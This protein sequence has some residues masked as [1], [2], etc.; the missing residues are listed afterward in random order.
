MAASS[1]FTVLEEAFALLSAEPHRLTIDGRQL[2]PGLPT[3]QI[4][5]SELRSIVVDPA[6]ATDLQERIIQAV[7]DRLQQERDSWVVV[8]GGLL[9]P[10]LR[11]LADEAEQG[12]GQSPTCNVE[13]ELLSRFLFATLRP[14]PDTHRFAMCVLQLARG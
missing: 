1:P 5:I 11:R 14:P 13:V 3:R 8:L 7:I 2:G 12:A 6:A 10:G 9:L 4:P